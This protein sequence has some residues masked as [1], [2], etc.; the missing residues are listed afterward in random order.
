M[1]YI[2]HKISSLQGDVWICMELLTTSLDRFYKCVH[3]N[4]KSIP[5]AVL[6][7]ITVCVSYMFAILAS[8]LNDVKA[9][10]SAPPGLI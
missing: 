4:D 2:V 1:K 6:G 8:S 3:S 5:E 10:L 9:L 7:K